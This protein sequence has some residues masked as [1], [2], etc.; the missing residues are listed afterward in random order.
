VKRSRKWVLMSAWTGAGFLLILL[1]FRTL[2]V[3]FAK[4]AEALLSTPVWLFVAVA[5]LTFANQIVGTL[6]WQAA[7]RYFATPVAT[8]GFL[9]LVELTSL[10]AFFG[11]FVPVQIS[12]IVARWLLLGREAREG[13]HVFK[14]SIFE[15]V[16]DLVLV[17]GGSIAGIA[18]LATGQP[19]NTAIAFFLGSVGLL[20]L[21]FG[22]IA[23][24]AALVCAWISGLWVLEGAARRT[25]TAFAQIADAP[26]A[27][28]LVL[29]SYSL[30]RLI[31]VGLRAVLVL[32]VFAPD[33][34]SWLVFVAS[35]GI[36]LLSALPLM[37][38]GIGVAEWS[39]SA[40]LI[41]GGTGASVAVVAA[42]NVRLINMVAL[43]VIVGGLAA[44]Q[45]VQFSRGCS[46]EPKA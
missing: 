4:A 16:F 36:S 17:L 45:R 19:P 28:V 12:T 44:L 40:I 33:T 9:R 31:L 37:P 46:L 1:L 5:S 2:D 11:Q 15:Q 6:K 43:I 30:V 38:A 35:P 34:A 41:M 39:W 13:G 21:F 26:S 18:V 20:L 29:A 3:S 42:L 27:I 32:L 23:R 8:P 14:A 25:S 10:G 22:P 7:A 24:F